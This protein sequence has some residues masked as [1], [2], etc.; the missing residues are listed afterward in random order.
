MDLVPWILRGLTTGKSDPR[1]IVDLRDRISAA[2]RSHPPSRS[3]GKE[4]ATEG[5]ARFEPILPLISVV[6]VL[7]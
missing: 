2:I 5:C 3:G 4:S 6:C 7:K 1:I